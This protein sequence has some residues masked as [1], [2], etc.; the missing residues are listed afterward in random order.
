[1]PAPLHPPTTI[2]QSCPKYHPSVLH[3]GFPAGGRLLG[4]ALHVILHL[5]PQAL[6]LHLLEEGSVK[7]TPPGTP[8]GPPR[9]CLTVLLATLTDPCHPLP[10]GWCRHLCGCK[11]VWWSRQNQGSIR[12]LKPAPKVDGVHLL[13]CV[14]QVMNTSRCM[15]TDVLSLHPLL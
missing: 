11:V 4:Q 13:P 6:N 2:R 12:H 9:Q 10:C 5:P 3:S 14:Q 1:M 15:S 7:P 8:H